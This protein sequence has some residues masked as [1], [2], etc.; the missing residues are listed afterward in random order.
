MVGET[1]DASPSP[2][3]LWGVHEVLAVDSEYSDARSH[4]AKDAFKCAL[5][6]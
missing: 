1:L 4:G 2:N 5:P 3:L 6:V